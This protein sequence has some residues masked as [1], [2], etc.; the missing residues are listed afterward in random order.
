MKTAEQWRKDVGH[1]TTS[2]VHPQ[3]LEQGF[4]EK[5]QSDAF[6]AGMTLAASFA[7][8]YVD[9]LAGNSDGQNIAGLIRDEIIATRDATTKPF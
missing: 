9:H 1:L 3:F 7:D 2:P 5:I 8:N 6:K 4:I